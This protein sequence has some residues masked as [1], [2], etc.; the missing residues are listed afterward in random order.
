MR[1]E[2]STFG[3]EPQN[4][5]RLISLGL[6]DF[7]DEAIVKAGPEMESPGGWIGRYKLLSVLGEGGMGIVYLAEQ[8]EPVKRE[9]A[10]KAIKPGMDSRRVLTRFEAEQ[11]ALALLEHPHV[12][13][14]YD[15]GLAPSGR[16]YFVMEYV[17]GILI[18]EHCDKY[19]L[20][21]QERL[22]LF[23][24]VCEAI[25]HAHQKGI[26]HRDLKPSN[27]LV[28]IQDQEMIPKVIDFGVARAISQPLTERTLYTEQ[29]QIIG[30]PEYMSPEQAEMTSQDID[31]RSDIYSMGAVLYELLTGVLPFESDTLRQGLDQL[32]QVIREQDPKTPS[33]RLSSMA[34]KDCT[35]IAQRRQ[36]DGSV[37]C[38]TLRGDLEW[39]V[40]KCLEKDRTRR[41]ETVNGLAMDLKRHLANEPVV[42]R[43]PTVGYRLQKA[44]RRNRL[45]YSAV[46]AVA[47]ALVLG[48]ALAA[49]GWRQALR[50]RNRAI[51]ARANAEAAQASEATLR[52]QAERQELAARRHAYAADMT[53]AQQ[54]LAENNLGRAWMLLDRQRPESE[55][56]DLRGWEWR[57]LWSQTRPD[58]HEVFFNGAKRLDGLEYS[59]DGRFLLWLAQGKMTVAS[60]QTRQRVLTRTECWRAAFARQTS[61]VAFAQ[62]QDQGD[63]IVV[64]DLEA[65]REV[66]RLGLRAEADWFELTPD[67]RLLLSVSYHRED[68]R[69][70]LAIWELATGEILW[71]RSLEQ[72]N[73]RWHRMAAIS[74]DGQ[75]VAVAAADSSFRVLQISDESEKF[76]GR[77][78]DDVVTTLTF[79]PDCTAFL[80]ATGYGSPTIHHWDVVTGK[81]VGTLEG[82]RSYVTDLQFTPDGKHLI[83]SSTDQTIRLWAW[84]EGRPTAILR[85]HSDEVDGLA[86]PSEGN[87]VASRCRDGSI[88]LWPLTPPVK[89]PAYRTLPVKVATNFAGWAQPRP[90]VFTPDSRTIIVIEPHGTLA[91]WDIATLRETRRWQS[92]TQNA[93]RVVLA[94]NGSQ[95]A[96]LDADGRLSLLDLTTGMERTNVLQHPSAVDVLWI[97]GDGRHL[98]TGNLNES[99]TVWH[100]R[101]WD[102]P[103]VEM[104]ETFQVQATGISFSN[105]L[106]TKDW[107]IGQSGEVRVW[108]LSRPQTPPRE[109]LPGEHGENLAGFDISPDGRLAAAVFGTGHIRVWDMQTAE[110]LEMMRVF[111]LA[112]HVVTFSPDGRRLAAG[113]DGREAVKLWVT[114]EW[115]EVLT[116]AGEGT[117]FYFVAFSPDGQTLMARNS[118]GLLHIWSAPSLKAIEKAEES[119]ASNSVT[120]THTL[121][122]WNTLIQLYKA[123]NKPEKAEEW[124]A[125]LL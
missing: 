21:I 122:S 77:I 93:G 114:A 22:H 119:T 88:F 86:V 10:L 70:E 52:Q 108:N 111:L 11:Q 110:Q 96:M 56:E 75:L 61:L 16:P 2:N 60:V 67:D 73:E 35:K 33:A 46:A 113:G 107:Y 36:V 115:Q 69:W 62:R 95:A 27:I 51:L 42:A 53:L 25:Q 79:S 15:A 50:E 87:T 41:Y 105:S 98:V 103:N 92:V 9:V 7:E 112:P 100:V 31:T 72:P 13:R 8:T 101:F 40:M 38:R 59:G 54:A 17:K 81:P 78:D 29:G 45:L 118:L 125:K 84:P 102:L 80:V 117:L 47:V 106:R 99:R 58:E 28:V 124:R 34:G 64:W 68:S 76:S 1:E 39:I 83:S 57:Y 30:T 49:S 24:H 6:E 4:L 91:Q 32:R 48:L 109:L 37:L 97:S 85:G 104:K 94:A 20:T 74:P 63:E 89:I 123:W 120:P 14:V 121:V 26:I 5:D 23:L 90:A 116:L 18:T 3:A 12:A 66:R 43:P 19:R 55:E 82:H 44:W 71:R 65:S